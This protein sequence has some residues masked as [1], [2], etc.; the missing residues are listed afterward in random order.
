MILIPAI[1]MKDGQCVRLY[2][3]NFAT[4]EQVAKDPVQTAKQFQKDGAEWIHMVDL[5][6]A[7]S[8]EPVNQELFL[9]I[10]QK[11]DCSIELGGGIRTIEKINT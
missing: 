5:D 10:A 8:G 2:Q 11:T 3:G 4:A 6:G 9:K 7:V 1:D